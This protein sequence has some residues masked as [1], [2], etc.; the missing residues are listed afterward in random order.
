MHDS[1]ITTDQQRTFAPTEHRLVR[2][3]IPALGP[4]SHYLASVRAFLLSS[5]ILTDDVLISA[6]S[7][8]QAKYSAP[9]LLA[10]H[11]AWTL[12]MWLLNSM[13]ARPSYAGRL[14]RTM[15][16]WTADPVDKTLVMRALVLGGIGILPE[17]V[18]QNSYNSRRKWVVRFLEDLTPSEN[19]KVNIHGKGNPAW[20]QKWRET[21]VETQY[22]IEHYDSSL[23]SRISNPDT[24]Y[25]HAQNSVT[26]SQ[27]TNALSFTLTDR[28]SLWS[29]SAYQ[30]LQCTGHESDISVEEV[31]R[32]NLVDP[33][34]ARSLLFMRFVAEWAGYDCFHDFSDPRLRDDYNEA[35]MLGNEDQDL[36][37][38]A[39]F[40]NMSEDHGERFVLQRSRPVL[41][42]Q[43]DYGGLAVVT[44]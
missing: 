20:M 42:S 18:A 15:R 30:I 22:D 32:A 35:D 1:R 33:V 17:L 5:T 28:D 31:A 4:I 43:Q 25:P 34:H 21:H 8:I 40:C 26:A 36:N 14:E 27:A 23:D 13:T 38:E 44:M 3:L 2:R 37:I 41:G 11:K 29:H 6:S 9:V 7:E 12:I 24:E 16:G 10:A 39:L 19:A